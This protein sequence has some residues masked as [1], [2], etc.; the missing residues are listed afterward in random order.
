MKDI[1]IHYDTFTWL[2]EKVIEDAI[3]NRW[4]TSL[5]YFIILRSFYKNNT[6]YKFSYRNLSKQTNI[7]Y[8]VLNRHI[9]RLKDKGLVRFHNGNLTLVGND[10]LKELYKS[11]LIAIPFADTKQK[12]VLNIQF[13]RIIKNLKQQK[14]IAVRKIETKKLQKPTYLKPKTAKRL[15]KNKKL[16][17]NNKKFTEKSVNDYYMLSNKKFGILTNRSKSTGIAIQKRL[18]EFG[19]INSYKNVEL[20]SEKTFDKRAFYNLCLPSSYQLAKNGKIY[21]VLPNRIEICN[22]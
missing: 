9:R 18:N 21:R 2:P 8:A 4:E 5:S 11:K 20:Y 22:K 6:F 1:S 16:L 17:L 13:T 3:N 10:K 7:S 12:T 15:L 19:L 14:H